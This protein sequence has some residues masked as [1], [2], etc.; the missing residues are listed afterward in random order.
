L[1]Q[2]I[3]IATD[4]ILVNTEFGTRVVKITPAH[5]PNEDDW[6]KRYDLEFI[7]VLSEDGAINAH[8]NNLVVEKVRYAARIA[9]EK[10]LDEKRLYHGKVQNKMRL[11]LCSSS[12]DVLE[13]MI[14]SQ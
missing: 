6:G 8:G 4:A 14:T 13:P 3:L 7:T 2:K 9:I 5:D 1:H 11:G 12:G 10:D